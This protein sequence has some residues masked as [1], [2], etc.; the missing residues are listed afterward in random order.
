MKNLLVTMLFSV[1]V[2]AGCAASERF[3][4]EGIPVEQA[5]VDEAIRLVNAADFK[6]PIERD[7][8]GAYLTISFQET[9][10]YPGFHDLLGLTENTADGPRVQLVYKGACLARS[11]MVHELLHIRYGDAEHKLGAK[12]WRAYTWRINN[13]LISKFC[14]T[15]IQDGGQI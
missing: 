3:T 10:D 2:C 12:L 9:V 1:R 5:Q 4:V 13:I 11:A 6:A 15:E 7:D 8:V 14:P